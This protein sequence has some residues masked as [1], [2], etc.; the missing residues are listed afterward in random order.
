[1][2]LDQ[3]GDGVGGHSLSCC[4]WRALWQHWWHSALKLACSLTLV[5][6]QWLTGGWER[7]R[8]RDNALY[9]N[10]INVVLRTETFSVSHRYVH[11]H[12]CVHIHLCGVADILLYIHA[13]RSVHELIP[14]AL[15]S[16]IQG[17]MY[18]CMHV[19]LT[20]TILMLVSHCPYTLHYVTHTCTVYI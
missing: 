4:H 19:S 6:L 7:G 1:M 9:N 10:L 5:P 15:Y 20:V 14:H 18:V 13:S 17:Y 16:L 2:I 11:V 8:E 3:M 12:V